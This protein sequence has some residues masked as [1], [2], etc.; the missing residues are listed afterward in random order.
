MKGFEEQA[1]SSIIQTIYSIT[2]PKVTCQIQLDHD[3]DTFREDDD[4]KGVVIITAENM[5]VEHE[6]IKISLVGLIG[7]CHVWLMH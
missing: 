7:R 4:V 5:P 2:G 6:G 1:S 3:R